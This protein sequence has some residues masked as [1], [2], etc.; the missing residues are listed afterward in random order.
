MSRRLSV[1]DFDPEDVWRRSTKLDLEETL[2]SIRQKSTSHAQTV[3]VVKCDWWMNL[4]KHLNRN[5]VFYLF[6]VC[7]SHCCYKRWSQQ[8]RLDEDSFIQVHFTFSKSWNN[9]LILTRDTRALYLGTKCSFAHNVLWRCLE[10]Q[11]FSEWLHFHNTPSLS[12]SH[13]CSRCTDSC[14]SLAQR[15]ER[16]WG[17]ML[18]WN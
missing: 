8:S 12:L 6:T 11:M 13:L 10:V 14:V 16:S 5:S 2:R 7:R 18:M 4:E 1:D 15:S 3:C 17:W 9:Q